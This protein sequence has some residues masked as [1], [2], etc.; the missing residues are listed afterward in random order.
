[1]RMG[2]TKRTNNDVITVGSCEA[3]L[4]EYAGTLPDTGT[5]CVEENLLGYSDQGATIEYTQ[6]SNTY[7]DDH[8]KKS[9]TVIAEDGA[10]A[11]LGLF[12]WNGKT[13]GKLVSTARVSDDTAKGLRT[14]KVGG[15]GNDNGKS[16][17]LCLHH[18][19]KQDGDCWYLIVGKNT[20]GFSLA[21]KKDAATTYN[22][23]FTAESQDSDGTLIT[24]IEEIAKAA[25]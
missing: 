6:T 11:A 24:Y 18:I 23:T 20:S 3:Y 22:P 5:I 8:G 9:K 7:T 16:Y 14:V 12:T 15:I 4:V 25:G 17:V 10:T 21:Y 2:D 1:M 13:M 19:D